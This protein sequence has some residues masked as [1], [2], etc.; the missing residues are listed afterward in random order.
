MKHSHDGVRKKLCQIFNILLQAINKDYENEEEEDGGM[1]GDDDDGIVNK[2]IKITDN[3]EH[4]GEKKITYKN[5]NAVDRMSR[6]RKIEDEEKEDVGRF[7]KPR[8]RYFREGFV[9]KVNN[10]IIIIYYHY[11]CYYSFNLKNFY[12]YNY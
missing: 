1:N 4:T 2:K 10:D 5:G 9:N 6:K 11:E 12:Y 7:F 8:L 3:Y